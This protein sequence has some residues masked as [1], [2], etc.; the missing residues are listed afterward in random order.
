M[1]ALL[2]LWS[3]YDDAGLMSALGCCCPFMMG[4]SSL[5]NALNMVYI[6][7]ECG[8]TEC[9]NS[10][11]IIQGTKSRAE[12]L[13]PTAEGPSSSQVSDAASYKVLP[14]KRSLNLIYSVS[15]LTF[16]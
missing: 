8:A 13:L 7:L 11:H 9:F 10:L 15:S 12:N 3:C 16:I 14:I 1:T 4:S 5:N 2:L 6:E